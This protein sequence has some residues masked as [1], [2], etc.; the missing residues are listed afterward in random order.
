MVLDHFNVLE[1]RH[2]PLQLQTR[3]LEA[4]LDRWRP[5]VDGGRAVLLVDDV[6]GRVLVLNAPRAAAA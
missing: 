4:F 2:E 3:S 1:H 6:Y 5:I